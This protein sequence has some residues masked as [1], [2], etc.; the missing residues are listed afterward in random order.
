LAAQWESLADTA[1]SLMATQATGLTAAE[2]DNNAAR[3]EFGS[4]DR[5]L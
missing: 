5:T 1:E 4:H 3:R 2:I